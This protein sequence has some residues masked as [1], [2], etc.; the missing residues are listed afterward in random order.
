M[1][2][3]YTIPYT[4]ISI[5]LPFGWLFEHVPGFKALRTPGRFIIITVL[6]L[7]VLS[8]YG[9]VQLQARWGERKFIGLLFSVALVVF[10]SVEY[11][12][13]PIP[14]TACIS[15]E[16]PGTYKWLAQQTDEDAVI[17][18]LPFPV[19][20]EGNFDR[21]RWPYYRRRAA[22]LCHAALATYGEWLQWVFTPRTRSGYCRYALL[23]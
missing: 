17:I 23:S 11:I 5:S 10:I 20:P 9:L 22:L 16:V 7:A 6:A 3:S 2:A 8:G 12:T 4:E 19:T 15:P 18:E 21:V 14:L 1:G 13:V